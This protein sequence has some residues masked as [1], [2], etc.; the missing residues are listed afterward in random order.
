[1]IAAIDS[2][3][4]NSVRNHLGDDVFESIIAQFNK[5]TSHLVQQ[6][7]LAFTQ[8]DTS[9][10]QLLGHKLK[11]LSQQ[12]GATR[13]TQLACQLSNTTLQTV[14]PAIQAEYY[15]V[16]RWLNENYLAERT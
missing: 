4:F 6:L 1:M 9:H 12:V 3:T 7:R 14:L 2:H 11:T 8:N 13:L 10:I 16:V 15:H 5:E